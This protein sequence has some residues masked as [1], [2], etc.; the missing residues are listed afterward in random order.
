MAMMASC[1]SFTACS[2]DDDD[3]QDNYYSF[4][5]DQ[6][7]SS[8]SNFLTEMQT[9]ETAYKNEF[10]K[11]FGKSENPMILHGSPADCDAQV[12]SACHNA[13]KTLADYN[14]GGSYTFTE[15]NGAK[16]VYTVTFR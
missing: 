6:L 4:G 5:F 14:W 15:T 16:T 2:D 12:I 1:I 7:S 8:S 11:Q 13:E 9:I 10:Q 3:V